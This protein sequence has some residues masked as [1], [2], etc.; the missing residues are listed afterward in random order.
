MSLTPNTIIYQSHDDKYHECK[1][2]EDINY[3]NSASYDYISTHSFNGQRIKANR[4]NSS[5][6]SGI[7]YHLNDGADV[8]PNYFS[9]LEKGR[10][11][12]DYRIYPFNQS[13]YDYSVTSGYKIS[14]VNA[15]LVD[16]TVNKTEKNKDG[17]LALSGYD[18][19]RFSFRQFR[20]Y[21]FNSLLSLFR[22]QLLRTGR[23]VKDSKNIRA[24]RPGC[25][26]LLEF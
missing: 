8:N 6:T 3:D 12:T 16:T 17:Y 13:K 26:L 9:Y 20:S 7:V 22:K 18:D 14:S 2:D 1:V 15:S 4:T 25:F 5:S 11:V 19:Y 23:K 10:V 21:D 24:K